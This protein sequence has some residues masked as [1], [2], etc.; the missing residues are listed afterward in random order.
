MVISVLLHELI[1]FL[2]RA[3]NLL[4][5]VQFAKLKLGRAFH[6]VGGRVRRRSF[7]GNFANKVI[8]AGYKMKRHVAAHSTFS[9]H[10]K[11]AKTATIMKCQNALANALA[12]ERLADL[13]RD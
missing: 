13:L 8:R 5:R 10:A 11:I 3:A 4:A 9:F 7:Y 1:D 6:L 12:I 2:N